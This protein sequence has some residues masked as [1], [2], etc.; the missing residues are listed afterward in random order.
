M[1]V[2]GGLALNQGVPHNA[3]GNNKNVPCPPTTS[4]WDAS[5]ARV[6][7]TRLRQKQVRL[8]VEKHRG[9]G[10]RQSTAGRP[11]KN[12]RYLGWWGLNF[13]PLTYCIWAGIFVREGTR[14]KDCSH[15][16]KTCGVQNVERDS[17]VF[18][19][20]ERLTRRAL[21]TIVYSGQMRCL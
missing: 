9:K 17:G 21:S 19:E 16:R 5:F 11:D 14:G 2:T 8:P 7:M 3:N 18:V 12:A 15:R 13:T 1:T 10:W 6:F 4:N 20:R